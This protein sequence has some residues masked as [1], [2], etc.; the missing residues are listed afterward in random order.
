MQFHD[1]FATDDK[2]HS[3]VLTA[4]GCAKRLIDETPFRDNELMTEAVTIARDFN[5][6]N[7][8]EAQ[9]RRMMNYIS[10]LARHG[11]QPNSRQ[12]IE[13][14][15]IEHLDLLSEFATV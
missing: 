15:I 14:F 10:I 9:E 11:K 2:H 4:D 13:S 8:A 6:G 12:T 7:A 3:M 1:R 5:M